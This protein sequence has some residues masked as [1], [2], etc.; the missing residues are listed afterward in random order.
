MERIEREELLRLR[1]MKIYGDETFNVFPNATDRD[2]WINGYIQCE[3][4]NVDKQYTKDDVKNAF[5]D[6]F[7]AGMCKEM[8]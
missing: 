2:I 5:N 6:G 8:L 7:N 4:D 1:F 3:D